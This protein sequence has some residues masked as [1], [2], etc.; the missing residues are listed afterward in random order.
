MVDKDNSKLFQFRTVGSGI[1]YINGIVTHRTI[2]E[3]LVSLRRLGIV[4]VSV[5]FAD[6]E[7]AHLA[8]FL[9][10]FGPRRSFW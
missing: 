2:F 8:L 6:L 7:L 9:A 5:E 4:Q 1:S 3:G 10:H